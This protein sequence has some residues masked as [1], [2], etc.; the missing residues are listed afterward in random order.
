MKN[1]AAD[2]AHGQGRVA[3]GLRQKAL[4][5]RFLLATTANR[6]FQQPIRDHSCLFAVKKRIESVIIRL[7][8]VASEGGRNPR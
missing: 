6:V 3:V 2:A 7:P 5:R 1:C 4:P 8:F